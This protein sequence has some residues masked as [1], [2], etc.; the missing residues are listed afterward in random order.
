M[1]PNS[2]MGA[3]SHQQLQK[4]GPAVVHAAT[5]QEHTGGCR[6]DTSGRAGCGP[7]RG[8]MHHAPPIMRW[9]SPG[10]TAS[11]HGARRRFDIFISPSPCGAVSHHGSHQAQTGSL[12]LGDVQQ[13]MRWQTPMCQHEHNIGLRQC[14][15]HSNG[16]ISH[17][18]L[19]A[20]EHQRLDDLGSSSAKAAP[21]PADACLT[22]C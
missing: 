18:R 22:L 11:G 4:T 12:Q 15:G 8:G 5:L 6:R 1:L 21:P 14:K 16:Q 20:C 17:S 10:A 9:E 7:R 3:V 13:Q 19:P 2:A